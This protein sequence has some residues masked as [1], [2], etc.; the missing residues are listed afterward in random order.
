MQNENDKPGA[1]ASCFHWAL[2]CYNVEEAEERRH[3]APDW[4]SILVRHTICLS[5]SRTQNRGHKLSKA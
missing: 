4:H 5:K 1:V 3:Q 2:L